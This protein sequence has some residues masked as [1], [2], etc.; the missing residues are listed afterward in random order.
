MVGR[1]GESVCEAASVD[2][3]GEDEVVRE[4]W[5][6]RQG[7]LFRGEGVRRLLLGQAGV[8]SCK[9]KPCGGLSL[10]YFWV[11]LR[12]RGLVLFF[13]YYICRLTSQRDLSPS[14]HTPFLSQG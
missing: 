12:C 13:F 4:R 9:V 11:F 3:E 7:E 14:S 10:G 5:S 2:N 1:D 8:P 6:R